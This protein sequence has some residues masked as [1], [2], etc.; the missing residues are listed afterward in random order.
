M[1]LVPSGRNWKIEGSGSDLATAT[2]ASLEGD[3]RTYEFHE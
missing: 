3:K 2:Y 1:K